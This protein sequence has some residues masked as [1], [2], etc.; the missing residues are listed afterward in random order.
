MD[1]LNSGRCV[2]TDVCQCIRFVKTCPEQSGLRRVDLHL[3]GSPIRCPSRVW[4]DWFGWQMTSI[5]GG[6]EA[7]RCVHVHPKMCIRDWVADKRFRSTV[8]SLVRG[9][10]FAGLHQEDEAHLSTP[11]LSGMQVLLVKHCSTN[12]QTFRMI[13]AVS[14]RLRTYGENSVQS[15]YPEYI[16]YDILLRLDSWI[17]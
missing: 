9:A 8:L 13:C 17:S 4:F 14:G 3:V 6:R 15:G 5:T 10:R 16:H 7:K 2:G 1:G 11:G 12:M